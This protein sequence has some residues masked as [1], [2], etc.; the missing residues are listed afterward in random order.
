MQNVGVHFTGTRHFGHRCPRIQPP[1]GGFL[2]LPRE[3]P[4][5]K[6]HDTILHSLRNVSYSPISISGSSPL[7]MACE[8]VK[9]NRGG[10]GVAGQTLERLRRATGQEPGP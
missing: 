2:K 3:L 6:T 7:E 5:I 4:S 9:A 1:N 8:K 10:G